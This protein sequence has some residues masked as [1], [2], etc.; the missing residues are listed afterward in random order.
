MDGRDKL[1]RI[2]LL[3]VGVVLIA[4]TPSGEAFFYVGIAVVFLS[5]LGAWWHSELLRRKR[6]GGEESR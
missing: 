6:E 5:I 4:A 3:L 2:F 1:R